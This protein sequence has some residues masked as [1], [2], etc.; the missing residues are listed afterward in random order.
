MRGRSAV[1]G[2]E[3]GLLGAIVLVAAALRLVSLP[4]R[5]PWDADQGAHLLVVRALV[6]E[7][8]VP[9]VGP[10][11]SFGTIHH[12]ALYYDLLAPAA[13]LSG[14]DP[15]VVV[16]TIVLAGLGALVATWWLAR[17]L[18][19]PLAGAIA[20]GVMA[21]SATEVASSTFIWNPTLLPLGGSL[22]FAGATWAWLERRPA[23]WLIAATGLLVAMQAHLLGALLLPP[24][25]A[26]WALDLRGTRGR[27]GRRRL[28]TA[29][30]GAVAILVLGHVQLVAN[31]L[32]TGFSETRGAVAYL[33]GG[34][35]AGSTVGDL[36]VRLV[37]VAVRILSWPFTG[38]FVDAYVPAVL[39]S[40]LV[41]GL[42]A[43]RLRAARLADRVALTWIAATLGWCWVALALAVPGLATVVRQLPFDHYHAFLDPAVVA[44]VAIG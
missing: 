31:E 22:A 26:L 6:T 25:V 16:L 23:G 20:A 42:L 13:W 19:G 40:G 8:K 12:G 5:G 36:P 9:L 35:A 11:T 39:V 2:W 4:S 33:T 44:I 17:Q 15:S 29:G 24:L 41:L 30:V 21:V 18:G 28:L 34:A 27:A 37:L 14:T 10:V 3:A 38:L 43:W 1:G 32:T 7:G